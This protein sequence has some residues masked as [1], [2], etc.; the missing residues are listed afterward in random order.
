MSEK[1]EHT[2]HIFWG[3]V[4][5]IVESLL[6][7]LVGLYIGTI[8]AKE[9][10]VIHV[11]DIWKFIILYFFI[12]VI[13][14]LVNTITW[15]IIRCQN[16]YGHTELLGFT[17][18]GLRGVMSIVF[19]MIVAV[20]TEAGSARFRDLCLFFAAIVVIMSS[21][22]NGMSITWFWKKIKLIN[23][24][25]AHLKWAKIQRGEIIHQ[26]MNN[27]LELQRHHSKRFADWDAV[28]NLI[29][30]DGKTKNL[31]DH[32]SVIHVEE[33][34]YKKSDTYHNKTMGESLQLH[35]ALEEVR[36]RAL[37][38]V[39]SETQ[40]AREASVCPPYVYAYINHLIY[41]EKE[42][43][44]TP[45]NVRNN[46]YLKNYDHTDKRYINLWSASK[47]CC[48]GNLLKYRAYTETKEGYLLM[49]NLKAIFVEVH[50]KLEDVLNES[51]EMSKLN[52]EQN[53]MCPVYLQ[54]IE[55]VLVE[56]E[57]DIQEFKK[58]KNF[59]NVNFVDVV[60]AAQTQIAAQKVVTKSIENAFHMGAEG[61]FEGYEVSK[62]ERY[63][64]RRLRKID[65]YCPDWLFDD[66]I[67]LY[68]YFTIFS[69]LGEEDYKLV[70]KCMNET[71][72]NVEK[73]QLIYDNKN[74]EERNQVY[75]IL[76]GYGLRE[77]TKSE[78]Y[79]KKTNSGVKKNPL[80]T[81]YTKIEKKHE[82]GTYQHDKKNKAGKGSIIGLGN[83]L[84]KERDNR[85]N[86]KVHQNNIKEFKVFS[87]PENIIRD[88]MCRNKK[89]RLKCYQHAHMEWIKCS[90]SD[91][92]DFNPFSN[93]SEKTMYIIS[94]KT[95]FNDVKEGQRI[96][97]ENGGFLISGQLKREFKGHSLAIKAEKSYEIGCNIPP[98]IVSLEAL[99]DSV[100]LSYTESIFQV[101]TFPDGSKMYE[102]SDKVKSNKHKSVVQ[103]DAGNM[104]GVN[105]LSK[106][107]CSNGNYN[108]FIQKALPIVN[109]NSEGVAK[110]LIENHRNTRTED[111][112]SKLNKMSSNRA[113]DN[114]YAEN[115]Y[116]S[117]GLLVKKTIKT[118]K[119][120]TIYQEEEKMHMMTESKE[121]GN[122]VHD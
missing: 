18:G 24:S 99:K 58:R 90:N 12:Y 76:Q 60:S 96:I 9:N 88:F 1:F 63:D 121:Y 67:Q 94:Q 19:A 100:V 66:D 22:I 64:R 102:V 61:L 114:H 4:T 55:I 11:S 105:D 50:E 82:P 71:N 49:F 5:K 97:V 109:D 7:I 77:H 84:C 115:L 110:Q 15:P 72:R 57:K 104:T 21:V 122:G 54:A 13:R 87:I 35:D 118:G 29:D 91:T 17:W 16:N 81:S 53:H 92:Y 108:K 62:I 36:L 98:T 75:F 52:T 73:G 56:I 6:Y 33:T 38:L 101:R 27:Y 89:F 79:D 46:K 112:K 83:I 69:V 8:F 51:K 40:E 113:I 14:F 45:I 85:T 41:L 10:N 86:L 107:M 2:L 20:D 34:K 23:V 117:L 44:N 111:L 116:A 48:I 103:K 68:S 78:Q 32:L 39:L 47:M 3:V 37:K 93:E 65:A 30:L 31:I 25:F 42:K 28:S 120:K 74:V 70:L 80:N 106:P 119:A 59:F 95:Q 26:A 43:I